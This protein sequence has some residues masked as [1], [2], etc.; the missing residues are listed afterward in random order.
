MQY[1]V[2]VHSTGIISKPLKLSDSDTLICISL[3]TRGFDILSAFP[4][5]RIINE[6]KDNEM[7]IANLGLLGKMTGAAAVI[8]S[9]TLQLE[10]EIVLIE[11]RLKAL[12]VLGKPVDDRN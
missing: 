8:K 10:N 6:N 2:R 1:I 5:K 11:T 12:G 4:L 9:R 3:E 7:L